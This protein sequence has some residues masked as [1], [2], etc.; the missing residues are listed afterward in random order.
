MLSMLFLTL[1]LEEF[2]N[3]VVDC[4]VQGGVTLR[5]AGSERFK[6]FV[7]ALTH[8]YEPLSTR[9]ILRRIFELHRVFKPALAAFLCNQTVAISLN[10]DGLSNQNLKGF[11]VVT[12]HWVNVVT[13]KTKIILLTILD[14]KCGAGV[15]VRVGTDL[16]EYL[17]RMAEINNG[18]N[19]TNAVVRLFK[20]VNIFVGYEQVRKCNHVRCADHFVQLAVLQALKLIRQSTEQLRDGLV[21]MR[22][23]KVIRQQY[24]IEALRS[25]L[26]STEPTHDDISHCAFKD[27]ECKVIASVSNFLC[28][29]RQVMESLAAD[30]KPTLNFVSLS[31]AILIKHCNDN[32][33]KLQEIHN[34]LTAIFMKMKLQSYE[35]KLVQKPTIIA[36]YLNPQIP[37]PTDTS[38]LMVVI[39]IVRNSG[40]GDDV[41]QYLLTSVVHALDFID[42]LSW[43]SAWKDALPGHYQMAMDYLGTP[44]T[45]TPSERVY[46]AT[47]REFTCMRQSLPSSVFIMVMCLRL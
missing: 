27:S 4:V 28:A 22:R 35:Q 16:F 14:V 24:R 13:M 40:M 45:S 39:E 26:S 37:K 47:G 18:T 9:T 11:Y 36:A 23:S 3:I 25:G 43:W 38:E 33:Q 19:V 8:G 42:V 6:K 12:A 15:G 10:L 5:A 30:S 31:I 1:T 34:A 32:E 20:L 29:P 46:S 2:K 7:V 44:A 17:K 41:D 21:K